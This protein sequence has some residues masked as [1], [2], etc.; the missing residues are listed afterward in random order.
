MASPDI[1]SSPV[2]E[3]K[4]FNEL[5]ARVTN[6]LRGNKRPLPEEKPSNQPKMG[7]TVK[8]SVRE[9]MLFFNE[10]MG[11]TVEFGVGDTTRTD[12]DLTNAEI[13]YILNSGDPALNLP[14]RPF[15]DV[16]ANKVEPHVNAL[17][18]QAAFALVQGKRSE[19][20]RLFAQAGEVG[21]DAIRAEIMSGNYAPLAPSTI[22]DRQDRGNPST[23][24]L[25]D[26]E[27]MYNAITSR[28]RR[29]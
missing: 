21:A 24:P 15:L 28:V 8:D 23:K 16:A 5:V 19:A 18:A 29:V 2:R 22:K 17:L 13:A 26:T 7:V 9:S 20:L 12:T 10:L 11:R 14:P 6:A 1:D 27:Q 4:A 3:S 25:Y